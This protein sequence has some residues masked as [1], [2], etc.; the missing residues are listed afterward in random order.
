[1][2][3]GHSHGHSC[4]HEHDESEKEDFSTA[5]HLHTKIKD[6]GFNV[7]GEEI[8]GAGRK[9]FKNY[10][11]RQQKIEF[12]NTDCDPELIFNIPFTGNI[13]LKSFIV[14]GGDDND[15]PI[16]VKLFKNQPGMNFDDCKNKKCDQEFQI[17]YD[18]TG[19]LQYNV[20]TTKFNGV[21]HLTMFFT[22][23]GDQEC[24]KIFYIGLRGDWE[25]MNR[26]EIAI[27]N[28]ELAANPADH[29]SKLYQA[30]SS[31]IGH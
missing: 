27:C 31:N 17:A 1:M 8:E 12:T 28:Y 15:H 30:N 21:H 26:E 16:N 19:V 3:H 29:K 6:Q 10:D 2:S 20:K 9:I 13:K 23:S 22:D 18:P 5:F 14:V 25:K 11:E 7:L 24:T 4:E